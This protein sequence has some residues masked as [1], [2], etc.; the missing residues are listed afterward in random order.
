MADGF[1]LIDKPEGLTSRR[2]LDMVI[3]RVGGPGGN[4]GT[5]DPFASGLIIAGLGTA[6]R[7]MR[8]LHDLPKVY[9]AVL[10][11]GRETDSLDRDG[12][13]G[14]IMP[15]PVITPEAADAAAAGLVGTIMQVPPV[16]SA[17]KVA[18]RRAYDLA[19]EGT[20]VDMA[21]RPVRVNRFAITAIVR[22]RVSFTCEVASGTYVRALGRDLAAAFG[23][24]GHL[25][26]LRRVAIRPLRADDGVAPD[27]AALTSV[28]PA[29]EVLTWLPAYHAEGAAVAELRQGHAVAA[30][31]A[32]GFYRLFA[33][34]AFIGAG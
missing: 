17:L 29:G 22:E 31:L 11:L 3:R 15:V 1:I 21:P 32:P 30:V 7:F 9:E 27:A 20:V 23:T 19:R 12:T 24:V 25:E 2:A 26:A 4:E 33:E 18:G 14:R 28:R 5:L 6:T 8:F 34:G 13:T 16:F 10:L